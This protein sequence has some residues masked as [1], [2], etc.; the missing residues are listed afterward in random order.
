MPSIDDL[1]C[2]IAQLRTENDMLKILLKENGIDLPNVVA[3]SALQDE[4]PADATITKRS[5]LP[6][7][8]ALFFSLFQGRLDVYARRWETKNGRS[9]YSPACINEWKPGVCLK[10]KGKCADCPHPEYYAYDENAIEAHLILF[11]N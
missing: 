7:K 4:S 1:M 8:A 9:G 11:S 10:P 6:E 2:E 3:D 5:P